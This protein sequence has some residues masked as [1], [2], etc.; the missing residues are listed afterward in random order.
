MKNNNTFDSAIQVIKEE[1]CKLASRNKELNDRIRRLE[2]AS[3][4]SSE[5]KELST[6]CRQLEAQNKH[7]GLPDPHWDAL[8]S[9]WDDH[10]QVHSEPCSNRYEVFKEANKDTYKIIC[11][12]CGSHFEVYL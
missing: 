9:W 10:K 12:S 11:N 2:S 5:L 3:Y 8:R 6:N 1:Y 7:L 4:N